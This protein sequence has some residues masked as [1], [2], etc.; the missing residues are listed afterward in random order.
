[1][2][3]EPSTVQ[4]L[5]EA[6]ALLQAAELSL[7]G[8]G[9]ASPCAKAGGLC[10]ALLKLWPAL[11]TFVTVAGVEPTNNVAE[12]AIRPAVL[13]RKGCFG[14]QNDD[15]ALVVARLL[16]VAAT[17]HQQQRALLDDLTAVC[18][19]AQHGQPIPSLLPDLATTPAA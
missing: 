3:S 5:A 14:S 12:R 15:G 19:V 13:W 8:E 1:M 10:R 9:A 6:T 7:L 4:T 11:W 18:T 17:C 16:S 2:R